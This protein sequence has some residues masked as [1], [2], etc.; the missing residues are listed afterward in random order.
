MAIDPNAQP[1]SLTELR[2]QL[3]DLDGWSETVIDGTTALTKTFKFSNFAEA[4]AF[5]NKVG[6]IAEAND[7]HPRISLTW[8]EATVDWWS[9]SAGGVTSNDVYM[10]SLTV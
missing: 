4:L 8:G 7:H 5:T 1:L 2:E 9:H 3:N 6:E 10:A